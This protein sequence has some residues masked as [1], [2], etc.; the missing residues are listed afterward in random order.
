MKKQGNA[1]S[2]RFYNPSNVRA[3]VPVD[4]DEADSALERFLR[5]KYE[6]QTLRGGKP[7]LRNNTGSTSSDDNPPP[8]PPK[9]G[10]SFTSR[11]HFGHRAASANYPPSN[12][13]R[14]DRDTPPLSLN[15]VR[16]KLS[17]SP[18]AYSPSFMAK[19]M[20]PTTESMD[21]KAD[22][23]AEMGFPDRKRNEMVLTGV[24]GDLGRATDILSRLGEG[25]YGRSI[26]PLSARPTG[27]SAPATANG[28]QSR[29]P[30]SPLASNNPF[31][32]SVERPSTSVG[33]EAQVQPQQQ[34][35][36]GFSSTVS[37]P[38]QANN[39]N[40]FYLQPSQQPAQQQSNGLEQSFQHL[41]LSNS[42]F[43]HNTGGYPNSQQAQHNLQQQNFTPPIPS[44]PQQYNDYVSVPVQ[45]Q[46]H[47]PNGNSNPYFSGSSQSL[48]PTPQVNPYLSQQSSTPV[49]Q[50]NGYFQSQPQQQV[51]DF[52]SQNP[53]GQQQPQISTPPAHQ[54]V[55]Q[56]QQQTQNPFPPQQQD[57]NPYGQNQPQVNQTP[58]TQQPQQQSQNPFPLP[59]QP[60]Q[61]SQINYYAQGQAHTLQPQRTGRAGKA[62]IMALFNHPQLAPP[63]PQVPQQVQDQ[64]VNGFQN[65]QQLPALPGNPA[66]GGSMRSVSSPISGLSGNGAATSGS[67][68]PFTTGPADTVP[69]A[70]SAVPKGIAGGVGRTGHMT[71]ESVDFGGWTAGTGGSGRHSP[72]AFS[73]LSSRFMRG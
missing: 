13:S 1:A 37:L 23:L 39:Q 69:T 8:L 6:T 10:H 27:G 29:S 52:F 36:N 43:P 46:Q 61:S 68:N 58:Y 45:Q 51:P 42:L 66:M 48:P 54:Q 50:N 67:R 7:Q 18:D 60:I 15:V 32:I 47:A 57:F 59:I 49:P 22:R 20:S 12:S 38:A 14:S 19:A 4:I 34:P 41:G 2:N 5:Q 64:N 62:D 40:P 24:G 3:P 70:A 63:I 73:G 30:Q 72:D 25:G 28:L 56:L 26:T 31:G 21:F 44:V 55:Q 65:G 9:N 71:Q 33:I 35:I 53:F 16:A 11:F 17:P